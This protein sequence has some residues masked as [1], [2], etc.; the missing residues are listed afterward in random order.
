[1]VLLVCFDVVIIPP[2][3]N[4]VN[5]FYDIFQNISFYILY[6]CFK[7]I[8]YLYF[9]IFSDNSI[10]DE[11]SEFRTKTAAQLPVQPPD[12][13]HFFLFTIVINQTSFQDNLA[14]IVSKFAQSQVK[15]L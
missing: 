13:F 15:F 7:T 5:T 3:A 2:K 12:S 1:M 6:I 14:F 10:N 8:I 11:L 9:L 4:F